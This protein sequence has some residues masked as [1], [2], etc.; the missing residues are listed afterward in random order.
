MEILGCTVM[1]K[2]AYAAALRV[3]GVDQLMSLDGG[4]GTESFMSI[5]A[6]RAIL[7]L[8]NIVREDSDIAKSTKG[9]E[10][11]LVRWKGKMIYHIYNS[12]GRHMH[13]NYI[14]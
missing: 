5:A 10:E 3:L 1:Q 14:R 9:V 13:G 7:L 8:Q 12:P 6:K 4:L 11:E 2:A